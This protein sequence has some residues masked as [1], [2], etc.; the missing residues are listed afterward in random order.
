MRQRATAGDPD[1]YQTLRHIAEK[2]G[3]SASGQLHN[4]ICG[5][6]IRRLDSESCA[7]H[8]RFHAH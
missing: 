5:K 2:S 1:D 6:L 7:L 3:P 4:S 8:F